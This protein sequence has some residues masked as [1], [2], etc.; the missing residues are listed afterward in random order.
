M[1]P[2]FFV[3]GEGGIDRIELAERFTSGSCNLIDNEDFDNDGVHDQPICRT[4]DAE[5]FAIARV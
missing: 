5:S 3:A 1:G 4:F 2:P